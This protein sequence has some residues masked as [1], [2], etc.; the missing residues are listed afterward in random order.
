MSLPSSLKISAL[1]TPVDFA[2]T[3]ASY[4]KTVP[5]DEEN[6][7]PCRRCLQD[8]KIGDTMLLAPYDPFVGDSPYRQPGPIFIHVSPACEP[9]KPDGNVPTQLSRRLLA[10]RSFGEDHCLVAADVVQGDKLVVVSSKMLENEKAAYIHVHNA[11]P[12][13]FA[14]RIDR[15]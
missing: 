4:T 9:Y 6:S 3:P 1:P 7:F 8:G 13:C 2:A 10:L 14:A 5:V 11:R 15:A 12:G